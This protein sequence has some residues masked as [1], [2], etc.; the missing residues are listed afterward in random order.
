MRRQYVKAQGHSEAAEV[1]ACA[2]TVLRKQHKAR[3]RML[4]D[5]N[6]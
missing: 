6:T 1:E 3:R 2:K 4:S 5:R